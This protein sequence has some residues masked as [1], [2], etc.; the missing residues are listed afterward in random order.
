MDSET[1]ETLVNITIEKEFDDQKRGGWTYHVEEIGGKNA[2][3]YEHSDT[4][5]DIYSN[6][7]SQDQQVQAFISL[8]QNVIINQEEFRR[9][10]QVAEYYASGCSLCFFTLVRLGFI[11]KALDALGKRA[12]KG[13][14]TGDIFTLIALMVGEDLTYFDLNQLAK[15]TEIIKNL[16]VHGSDGIWRRAAMEQSTLLTKIRSVTYEVAKKSIRG[17]N[18]E[19]NRDKEEVVSYIS[20]FE[21]D[22]KYNKLLSE[23]D[24][25]IYTESEIISSGMIGNLRSF[26]EDLL[27]DLAKKIAIHEEGDIPQ[28]EGLGAMGCVRKYLKDNLELSDNDNSFINAYISVLHSEGGHSFVSN[29]DYFRLARNIGIEIVL[30]L[31]SKFKSKYIKG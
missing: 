23:I 1:V 12:E 13:K 22:D 17:V 28:Y 21:F 29:K 20:H 25:Y 27:T 18:I 5:I 8:L 30:L 14:C 19:I 2:L 15:L 16:T 7:S 31:L 26:M 6:I 4:L 10:R 11:D 9:V 3:N 24:K